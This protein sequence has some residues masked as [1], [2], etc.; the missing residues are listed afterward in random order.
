[1]RC[2]FLLAA[3][4]LLVFAGTAWGEEV[5]VDFCIDGDMDQ[6]C[7]EEFTAYVELD[8]LTDKNLLEVAFEDE[9]FIDNWDDYLWAV[10]IEGYGYDLLPQFDGPE[11]VYLAE[12]DE[13]YI[14][15]TGWMWYSSCEEGSQSQ[16]STESDGSQ[17]SDPGWSSDSGTGSGSGTGTGPGWNPGS[18]SS[19]GTGTIPAGSAEVKAVSS[20]L[21]GYTVEVDGVPIGIDGTG[22]D[23][24]D[25]VYTFYV[26]GNQQHKIKVDHPEFWKSWEEFFI[27]GR[28]Y[29]ADIDVPGRIVPSG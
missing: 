3:L 2:K 13:V 7:D 18:G 19:G 26:A 20:W 1:M 6:L 12:G 29:T 8:G 14:W 17:G 25:G 27:S 9:L 4:S 22:S 11:D 5:S 24:L 23:V 21:S 15:Y 28:R 10:T 16:D